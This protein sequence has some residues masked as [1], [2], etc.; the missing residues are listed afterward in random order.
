M[1]P[2][3]GRTG[4]PA[5]VYSTHRRFLSARDGAHHDEG[6]RE[7]DTSSGIVA[8]AGC[9]AGS[10][11]NIASAVSARFEFAFPSRALIDCNPDADQSNW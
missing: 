5:R 9:R 3:A 8:R 2:V 4:A 7:M 6:Q 10:Q 1:V 11:T